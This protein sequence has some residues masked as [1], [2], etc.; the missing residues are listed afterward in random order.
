MII[1]EGHQKIKL[2]IL[3]LVFFECLL[4]ILIIQR[5]NKR[6]LFD[7]E[8]LVKFQKYGLIKKFFSNQSS[9]KNYNYSFAIITRRHKGPNGLFGYYNSYISCLYIYL[10]NGFIPILDF[11]SFPNIFNHFKIQSLEK[12][13]NP[14]E[15]FFNQPFE[16]TLKYVK[17][18]AKKIRY[19]N[20]IPKYKPT[21]NI[22]KKKFLLSFWHDIALK[23]IPIKNEIIK[24]SNEYRKRLFNNSNN[25][26]GVL[27]RGTDY[28]NMKPQGHPVQPSSKIVIED[29]KKMDKFNK[30]D[31]IFLAT[32]DN[33]I[34]MKFI[35]SFGKKL[36]YIKYNKFKYNYYKKEY[37]AFNTNS[38]DIIEFMKIYLINIVILSKCI[39]IISS[40]TAGAVGVFIYSNG[41]RNAKV[42]YLGRYK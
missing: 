25:V 30:Y 13:D 16:Y 34:R 6:Y 12:D 7:K 28:T 37:I 36:K 4:S 15:F 14:W 29:V 20:C 8:I 3:L 17:K 10:N 38:I 35:S 40:R 5:T 41:F 22:F 9:S 32:E 27:V 24:K 42:Y 1:N 2:I 18:Y 39:D 19:V 31:W 23:Y 33:L 26:L 11:S 21:T